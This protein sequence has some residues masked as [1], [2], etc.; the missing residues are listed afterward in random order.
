MDQIYPAVASRTAKA[1]KTTQGL[2][3]AYHF[4]TAVMLIG[5]IVLIGVRSSPADERAFLEIASGLALFFALPY[6]VV[7]WGISKW[8]GW[9]RIL[10]LILIRLNTGVAVLTVGR[11]RINATTSSSVALSGLVLWSYL[12]ATQLQFRSRSETS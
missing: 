11:S 2:A 9:S 8:K 12:P 1:S 10:P 5:G 7:G 3:V 4:L 6:F